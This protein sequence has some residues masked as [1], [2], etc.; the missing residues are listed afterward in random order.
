MRVKRLGLH[1]EQG[2]VD[3]ALDIR[4]GRFEVITHVR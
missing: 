4:V 1:L 2:D 3:V